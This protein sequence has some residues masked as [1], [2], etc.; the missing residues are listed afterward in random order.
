LVIVEWQASESIMESTDA[1]SDHQRA[2]DALRLNEL[3]IEALLELNEMADR[4]MQII[5]DFSL[6]KAIELTRSKAGYLAFLN[7]EETLLTLHGWPKT[8]MDQSA[9]EVA[10]QPYR[11]AEMDRWAEAVRRRGPAITDHDAAHGNLSPVRYMDVPVFDGDR[12]VAVAGVGNKETPYDENDVRQLVLLTTGT[13]RLVQRKQGEDQLRAAAEALCRSEAYLAQAQRLTHTGTWVDDGRMRPVYWSEEH[14]R[15]F[16]LDPQRGL[17][18]RE[19][20]LER[21]HPDDRDNVKQ[22]FERAV[23]YRVDS[24]AEYRLVH[25][26]GTVRYAHSIGRPVLDS[27]GNLVEIVGTTVDVTERKRSAEALALTSFA[28]NNAHDAAALLNEHGRVLYVNDEAC[29]Q[30]GYT[31][32]ELLAMH[33]WDV[34]PDFSPE[35]WFDHW[36]TLKTRQ[37]VTFESCHRSKDGRSFPVEI[38]ARYVEYEGAAFN[39]AIVRDITERKRAE[40]ALRRSEA[41]LAEAQRLTHTGSWA[42]DPSTGPLYWSEELYRIFGL[43]PQEGIPTRSRALE[44]IHPEDRDK[45]IEAFNRGIREKID[46]ELDYRIVLPDATIKFVHG[47]GRPVY[48]ADGDL[49]E[50]VGTTVDN[51][52][53]KRAEGALRRSEAYLSEAQRLTHTGSWADNGDPVYWSEEHYRIFALDPHQGLPTREQVAERI[54]PDDRETVIR[55]FQKVR[56]GNTDGEA[57]YRIV[58][59]DGTLKYAH[60]IGHPVFDADGNFV[61]MVGTTI[62]ITERK[63]AEDERARLYQLEADLAH[64]NRVSMMGELAASIAH[65]VN[66]PLSGVVS[67]GSACLRWLAGDTP[68]LDEAREATRRIVRDGKR[69][70]EIIA[71]IRALTKRTTEHREKLNLNETIREILLLVGDEAKKKSMNIGTSFAEGL[72]PVVGDRVQLQQVILNLVMNGMEA[73]NTVTDRPRELVIT[74]RNADEGQVE[75]TIQDSGIGLDPDQSARIYD[76]F[77]TTKPTGMGMGLSISRSILQAHGGRLWATANDG[78]G[79]TFHFSLPKQQEEGNGEHT[80]V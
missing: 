31:R 47:I 4:P 3:R 15:I 45:F 50:I 69:A 17:P 9:V 18:S 19:G 43:D 77:Y 13:W 37:S 26:D 75:V 53:R 29:R 79:T 55:A 24:E 63:R 23:T 6:E 25:S 10:P 66:Q 7:E 59:P 74:T 34:N 20:A 1:T 60:G 40:E 67:N 8:G 14:Y 11:L 42:T 32:D 76:A 22:A 39:V 68:N 27:S 21:I 2:E 36:Q 52:E 30:S 56:L 41:Y 65:E 71:R 78:L 64:I 38:S 62:D 58:L 46:V 5:I 72:F 70:A 44:R 12:I 57:F 61:E 16:G 73:M 51:T 80:R 54:H 35:T 49:V 28:L 33:V 48:N